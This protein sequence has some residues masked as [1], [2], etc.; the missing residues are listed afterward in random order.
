MARISGVVLPNEKKVAI[1]LTAI[2]GVG[3]HRALEILDEADVDSDKRVKNLT[4]EEVVRL[5]KVVEKYPVGGSLKKKVAQDIQRL[6]DIGSYR[7]IRHK[8][9]LPVRGQRTRSNA[10]T[11]RGKRRTI[12]AMRKKMYTKL[13]TIKKKKE[14]KK[15]EKK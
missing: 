5:Q 11:K 4:S 9:G 2:Y 3:S 1:G 6:K 10:R 8:K 12:G 7:G 13:E 14:V 15:E